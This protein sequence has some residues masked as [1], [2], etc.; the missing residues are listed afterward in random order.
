MREKY[1]D[2]SSVQLCV[3][4]YHLGSDDILS[5]ERD[6]ILSSEHDDILSNECD[7]ILSRER[8]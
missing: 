4:I 8:R 2:F 6:D 7:D 3:M 5:T 1:L